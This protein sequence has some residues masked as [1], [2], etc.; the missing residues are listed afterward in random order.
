MTDLLPQLDRYLKRQTP[1]RH[2]ELV[3]MEAYAKRHD[4]PY[5]GP[6]VGRLLY[7]Y[8]AMIKARRVFELG[9]GFGFSAF[10]Y[11]LARGANVE[12]HLTDF[13][14]ENL[15]RAEEHFRN[16]KLKSKFRYHQGDALKSFKKSTGKFDIILSDIDK[17]FYPEVVRLA[18]P[19]LN[20][21]GLLISDNVIWS[22]KVFSGARDKQTQGVKD[23][24]R[25]VFEDKRLWT[26]IIP[27]RDGVAVSM[28]L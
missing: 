3:K 13:E 22:G 26:T 27:I 1:E 19:R 4:F 24:T 25:M 8:A 17:T 5:I 20:K 6:E 16:A 21:G 15:E 28:K 23:Y 11:A 18:V 7:Q 9:S 14:A 12:I 2:P 10:W